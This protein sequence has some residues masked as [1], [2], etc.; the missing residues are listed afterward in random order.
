MD[1]REAAEVAEALRG[2]DAVVH[3]AVGNSATT[4]EG[5]RTLLQ[6]AAHAGVRRIVH[7]SSVAVYGTTPGEVHEASALVA[8]KGRGYAHWK[9]AAEVACHAAA[10]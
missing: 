9:V 10:N 6:L 3:C 4:V 8:A 1:V 5:T 7:F 2:I